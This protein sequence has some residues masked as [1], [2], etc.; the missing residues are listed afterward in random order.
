MLYRETGEPAAPSAAADG[1]SVK[2]FKETVK[3]EKTDQGLGWFVRMG[4]APCD[5]N[6]VDYY[7]DSGLTYKGLIPGRDDDSIGV[8]FGYAQLSNGAQNSVADE[9]FNPAG[10]EM[11]IEATYQCQV[12]PWFIVQPDIQ[13]ILNPGGSTSLSNAFV[14][15]GRCSIVF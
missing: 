4:F 5:R 1:K 10:A 14:L 2:N 11:V 9:G 3:V 12:T 15:G 13:Y 6:F 7:F 8:G